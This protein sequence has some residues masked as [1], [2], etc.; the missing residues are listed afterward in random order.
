MDTRTSASP[1]QP[2]TSKVCEL[3]TLFQARP[4][5]APS[6]SPQL[7]LWGLCGRERAGTAELGKANCVFGYGHGVKSK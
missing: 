3:A 6:C 2:G 5:D 4:P 1:S 7:C